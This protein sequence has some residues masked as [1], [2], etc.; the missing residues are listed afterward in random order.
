[1]QPVRGKNKQVIKHLQ[2]LIIDE[3][4]MVRADLIDKI[5]HALK[6][7]RMNDRPFGGVQLVMIGDFY[8][9]P[10]VV[11]GS[12]ASMLQAAG[13]TTPYAPGAKA[14]R[15]A[16]LQTV[17]LQ[18]VFRQSD[19]EFIRLLGNIRNGQNLPDTL[20]KLNR[21]CVRS[22]RNERTPL[23][24]TG[25]NAEA[26]AY[27]HSMLAALPGDTKIYK[28]ETGGEFGLDGDQLPAPQQL[29]LKPHARV[30]LLKND[31]QK[32][33]VNGSLATITKLADTEIT[34]KL[35]SGETYKIEPHN[36][37]RYRYS[38][39]AAKEEITSEVIG[40]YNQMPVKLAWASTVHKA[41]GLSLEDVRVDMQRGA[42]ASGQVYVALSRA[43]SL[44]GLSLTHPL[45]P[46][47]IIIDK[48][49]AQM[50]VAI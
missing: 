32:R 24:L 40:T 42:F 30:M 13:Y 50:L 36:W 22:H 49:I 29:Q 1:M 26:D 28:G 38:W 37:E 33:W 2:R 27:N 3:I 44:A 48:Q 31:P 10:P 41:Q 9:L 6:I 46:S 19:P 18:Q 34:V 15:A 20:E 25:R 7:N 45:K 16:N 5:D 11:T 43:T 12:E 39:N 14:L 8:Q 35:D 21:D 47:D 17:E 4:S 23:L